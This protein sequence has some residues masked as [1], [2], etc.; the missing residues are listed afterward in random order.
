M[1]KPGDMKFKYQYGDKESVNAAHNKGKFASNIKSYVGDGKAAFENEV[2]GEGTLAKTRQKAIDDAKKNLELQMINANDKSSREAINMKERHRELHD[3]M[4]QAL[5]KARQAS[6][7]KKKLEAE[8]LA[9]KTKGSNDT[10]NAAKA[11]LDSL[12]TRQDIASSADA[13]MKRKD[14]KAVNE[15]INQIDDQNLISDKV[16]DDGAQQRR[17]DIDVFKRFQRTA[18]ENINAGTTTGIFNYVGKM[19]RR[20]Q[21]K[22]KI[23]KAE[24]EIKTQEDYILKESSNW[25]RIRKR[26]HAD[27][28]FRQYY[29]EFDRAAIAYKML[30]RGQDDAG[31]TAISVA[32]NVSE[33]VGVFDDVKLRETLRKVPH[34]P[35][36]S[37]DMIE[38]KNNKAL[39]A[40]TT[41]TISDEHIKA[42]T[43]ITV[44]SEVGENGLRTRYKFNS[45]F[46]GYEA[47]LQFDENDPT[48]LKVK[49]ENNKR[50]I[51]KRSDMHLEMDE[52]DYRGNF[53]TSEDNVEILEG[54]KGK[55]FGDRVYG[56][57]INGIFINSDTRNVLKKDQVSLKKF[58]FKKLDE[59]AKIRKAVL[60]A[61]MFDLIN[62]R[63]IQHMAGY[64]AGSG[65]KKQVKKLIKA[66]AKELSKENKRSEDENVNDLNNGIFG[67]AYENDLLAADKLDHKLPND[68]TDK[69]EKDLTGDDEEKKEKISSSMRSKTLFD[70]LRQ[71]YKLSDKKNTF[72]EGLNNKKSRAGKLLWSLQQDRNA[73]KDAAILLLS[74]DDEPA[75]WDMAKY[76]CGTVLDRFIGGNRFTYSIEHAR[77]NNGQLMRLALLDEL[78]A[79]RSH[80]NMD[81][82][83]AF[84]TPTKWK[85]MR[86]NVDAQRG[87]WAEIKQKL[88][89]GSL[90]NFANDVLGSVIDTAIAL[91]PTQVGLG[92][93]ALIIQ[94]YSSAV[95]AAVDVGAIAEAGSYAITD[96]VNKDNYHY[97]NDDDKT[98]DKKTY[99]ADE[100]RS[101]IGLIATIVKNT[102]KLA[103]AVYKNIQKQKKEIEA[104]A[105]GDPDYD[106]K[107]DMEFLNNKWTKFTLTLISTG[108]NVSQVIGKYTK[109]KPLKNIASMVKNIIAVVTNAIDIREADALKGRINKIDKDYETAI[110]MV[111]KNDASKTKEH[112]NIAKVL[113]ENSQLQYGL[114]CARSNANTSLI[115]NGFGIVKNS[116]KSVISAVKVFW[117]DTIGKDTAFNVVDAVS[118][119]VIDGVQMVTEIAR[120]RSI[121]RATIEKMLGSNFSKVDRDLLNDVLRREVGIV[122]VDYLTDLAKIFMSI[123]THVYLTKAESDTEKTIGHQIVQALFNN[124]NIT[125]NDIGKVSI[126]KLMGIMGVQNNF[127]KI[128]KHSLYATN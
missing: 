77:G 59:K 110:T 48:V 7:M 113:K 112:E 41:N 17:E 57:Y 91:D 44:L 38:I 31:V 26:D 104:K 42:H 55:W 46:E 111:D 93:E 62:S 117:P 63:S 89:N 84:T 52:K 76:I 109:I 124:K 87:T 105:K 121:T 60:K 86:E 14:D 22:N 73:L 9:E 23:G 11:E 120:N 74:N 40:G 108:A 36:L 10:A 82:P 64:E 127:H 68:I 1:S 88:T 19:W 39:R 94:A 114:S 33:Y 101:T 116:I 54:K 95:A 53:I 70:V 83:L 126:G 81:D 106:P 15:A 20:N 66:I 118:G 69:W 107:P 96:Y 85:Q 47:K 61:A 98:K 27:T 58:D 24:D 119:T 99:Y 100:K 75:Y 13:A 45:A 103:K 35:Y 102:L 30:S 97:L 37:G 16:T 6:R 56:I 18:D 71:E 90:T 2:Y 5:K 25:E 28:K 50:E 72:I 79:D 122:N 67:D 123:N 21:I 128:I 78:N 51:M 115:K 92:R 4:Q 3:K 65:G 12:V 29:E 43:K 34:N 125:K 80:F 32:K 49:N 8:L